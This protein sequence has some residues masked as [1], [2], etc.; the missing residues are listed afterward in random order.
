MNFQSGS[1]V[2]AAPQN[3]E[4]SRFPRVARTTFCYRLPMQASVTLAFG[5]A[6]RSDAR[7]NVAKSNA[8][9]RPSA[10]GRDSLG[11]SLAALCD[12][13]ELSGHGFVI[14]R[15]S[16]DGAELSRVETGPSDRG[17]LV[18]LSL[19][20]GHRRRIFTGT[21]SV[22]Y[23]F[24][25]D[26]CYIRPFADDYRAD[27]ETGFEFLLL[28][29]S[30]AALHH[31]CAEN[32]VPLADG[33]SPTQAGTDPVLAHLG[34]AVLPALARPAIASSLFVE[35]VVCAMQTHLVSRYHGTVTRAMRCGALSA[36]QVRR[37]QELLVAGMDSAVLIGDI[38]TACDVSRSYFIRAFRQ[39][40]GATPYQWLLAR[41]VERARELLTRS[42]L[43]LADVAIQ[44]GFSDQSHMTRTFA[45]LTGATPGAWR[46]AR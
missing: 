31:T 5:G 3:G 43:S 24:A 9:E 21:R 7:M 32:G 38:A 25:A 42:E 27:I 29:V 2:T 18:G 16:H 11:C 6:E 20:G 13:Q 36:T 8:A 22:S 35:Q 26:S 39:A 12:G 30:Q 33:L 15:K 37:A 14:Y 10:A 4:G 28:E 41:R 19:T 1:H 34:R 40:T 45:R 23:D 44:C 17:V 46:R